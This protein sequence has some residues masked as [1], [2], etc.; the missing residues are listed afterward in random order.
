[1]HKLLIRNNG[2]NKGTFYETEETR[3]QRTDMVAQGRGVGR[4]GGEFEVS[5]R[6]PVYI[7]W[8]NSKVLLIAQETI[9]SIL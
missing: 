4:E 9:F 8:R 1:M 5:R 2:V 3:R 6:T 7:E